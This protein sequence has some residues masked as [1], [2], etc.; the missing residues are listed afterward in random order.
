MKFEKRLISKRTDFSRT[1]LGISI[2]PFPMLNPVMTTDDEIKSSA[3]SA[4]SHSANELSRLFNF[5]R[6]EYVERTDGGRW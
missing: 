4:F 1:F 2:T 6:A 5:M 3:A